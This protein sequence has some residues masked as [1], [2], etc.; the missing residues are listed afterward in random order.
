MGQLVNQFRKLKN[1]QV[2]DFVVGI[3]TPQE[4]DHLEKRLEIVKQLKQG[5]SHRVIAESLN[6]GIATVTRGSRELGKGRFKYV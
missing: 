3:L 6:V 4:L 5:V 1:N 2:E